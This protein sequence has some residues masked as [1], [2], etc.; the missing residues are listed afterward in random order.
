MEEGEASKNFSDSS[1]FCQ[2]KHLWVFG[3]KPQDLSIFPVKRCCAS[4]SGL[5]H[6]SKW[7]RLTHPAFPSYRSPLSGEEQCGWFSR[8]LFLGWGA[9]QRKGRVTENE[10]VMSGITNYWKHGAD[11]QL[12][13]TKLCS[14]PKC[15]ISNGDYGKRLELCKGKWCLRSLRSSLATS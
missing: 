3:R 6:F 15:F 12:W 8:L 9:C 10:A 7:K 2:T 13:N 14:Q 11:K 4:D 5:R 1:I